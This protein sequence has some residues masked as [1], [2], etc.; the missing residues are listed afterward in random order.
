MEERKR[1]QAEID[2]A[3]FHAY[4]LSPEETAF[5]L[6]DFH[7]VRNPRLM[8]EEY[9]DL[10]FEKYDERA[11]EGPNPRVE[12]PRASGSPRSGVASEREFLVFSGALRP[13]AGNGR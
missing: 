10:V 7:R 9:F 4:G 3:A 5:V 6:D 8:T 12:H 11:T 1:L 2:A 13:R